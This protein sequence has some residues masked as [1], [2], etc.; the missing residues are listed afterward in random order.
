MLLSCDTVD[1]SI[2]NEDTTQSVHVIINGR[3]VYGPNN[4]SYQQYRNNA[5]NKLHN[6]Q[7]HSVQ[8]SYGLHNFSLG[9]TV[10]HSTDTHCNIIQFTLQYMLYRYCTEESQNDM[11]WTSEHYKTEG[12]DHK[13]TD[14][15]R[16]AEASKYR[17]GT[18]M[19]FCFNNKH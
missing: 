3:F 13:L 7:S 18:Y 15:K 17:S 5:K 9:P 1:N 16:Q 8:F 2:T 6:V 19:M 14:H 12:R 11:C 4:H 10:P